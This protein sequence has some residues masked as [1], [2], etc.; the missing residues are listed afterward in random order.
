MQYND[1]IS[2]IEHYYGNYDTPEKKKIMT[3]YIMDNVSESELEPLF[4]KI[5]LS[6]SS[7]YKTPPDV[8]MLSGLFSDK[9]EIRANN[10]YDEISK[11]ASA[12]NDL[13]ISDICAFMAFKNATGGLENFTRRDRTNEVWIKKRFIELYKMYIQNPPDEGIRPVFKGIGQFGEPVM[14]GDPEKCKQISG[15]NKL[16]SIEYDLTQ[17]IKRISEEV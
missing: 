8:A 15:E 10:L 14:I 5:I 6:I 2:A 12:Y 4:K 11:K 9:L 13:I 7:Q 16:T 3:E 17:N 1:F